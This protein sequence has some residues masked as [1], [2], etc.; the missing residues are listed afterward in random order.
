[1]Q[2]SLDQPTLFTLEELTF[3]CFILSFAF[4][5]VDYVKATSMIAVNDFDLTVAQNVEGVMLPE[6]NSIIIQAEDYDF[7][8]DASDE[9]DFAAVLTNSSQEKAVHFSPLE[10]KLP[11]VS[12]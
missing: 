5:A 4:D 12:A 11:P 1:M 3:G 2:F 9:G 10:L 6:V 8:S 7:S